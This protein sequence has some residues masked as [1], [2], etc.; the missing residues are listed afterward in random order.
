[1]CFDVFCQ[2]SISDWIFTV[3]NLSIEIMNLI[4][5]TA[6]SERFHGVDTGWNILVV[7]FWKINR[8]LVVD[9]CW[10]PNQ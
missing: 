9:E 4:L 8:H 7:N 10:L 3:W 1:M 2:W 6:S 5:S